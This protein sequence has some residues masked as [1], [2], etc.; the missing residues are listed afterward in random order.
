[1]GGRRAVLA[2]AT[3]LNRHGIL[4]GLGLRIL[5]ARK[6]PVANL[7]PALVVAPLLVEIV[8]RLH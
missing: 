1:M 5:N 4:V 7:L 3:G 2:D 8:A 6:V